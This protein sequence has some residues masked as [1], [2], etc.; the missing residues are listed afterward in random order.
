M[1][2]ILSILLFISLA[3]NSNAQLLWKISGNGQEKPSYILGT[4][5]L[6]PLSIKDS[7]AG[8]PQAVEGTTQVYGE[9][10]MSD[11][12]TRVYAGDATKYDDGRR[13]HSPETFYPGTI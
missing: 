11:M 12:I 4:H 6:A 2:K 1:K 10:V 3:L 7:I 13:H 9:V 8:L 5:H